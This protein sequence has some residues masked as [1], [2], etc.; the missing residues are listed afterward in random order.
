MATPAQGVGSGSGP[1]ALLPGCDREGGST[2][3]VFVESR[4]C[5]HG[6]I[7]GDSSFLLN[8]KRFA[9]AILKTSPLL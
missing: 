1:R 6:E 5:F 2:F 9:M 4:S 8:C 7:L 3:L